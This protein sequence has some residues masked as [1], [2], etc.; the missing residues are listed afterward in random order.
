MT[1]NS[2]TEWVGGLVSPPAHVMDRDEPYRVQLALWLELPGEM[3][4]GFEVVPPDNTLAAVTRSLRRAIQQPMTGR[5]RRPARVRVSDAALA[6][7]ARQVLGPDA[8]VEMAP[9]PELDAVMATFN[10]HVS[11]PSE[12]ASYLEQ[13]RI[14]T[15]TMAAFFESARL[16]YSV[17]PWRKASDHEIL[18]MEIPALGIRGACVSIIGILGESLGLIVFPSLQGYEAFVDAADS[19]G[20]GGRRPRNLGT[21]WVSLNFERG[22]DLPAGLRRE[23]AAHRW[24]VA[25]PEA[26]PLAMALDPDLVSRPLLSR[27]YRVLEAC[28]RAVAAFYLKHADLFGKDE[29]PPVSESWFDADDLEVR[30][31][32]PYEAHILFE[33][34]QPPRRQETRVGRN[35]P[36]PCGSGR[37]YKKCCLSSHQQQHRQ[38]REHEQVHERDLRWVAQLHRYAL[39]RFGR[40]F[41]RGFEDFLEPED[42]LPL[43][44]PWLVFGRAIEGRTVVDWFLEERGR[45]LPAADRAW[46]EA[47]RDAWLSLWEVT[48]VIPGERL[49][50]RDLLTGETREIREVEG[51]KFA[52]ARDTLLARVVDFEGVSLLCGMHPRVLPPRYAAVALEDAQAKL[53]RKRAVPP[54]RLND[55]KFGRHL[56]RTWDELVED[57]DEEQRRPREL[58]NTDGDP[59]LLTIDRFALVDT[60]T[61][62]LESRLLALP[63]VSGP[64]TGVRDDAPRV[65][66]FLRPGGPA[67]GAGGSTVIGRAWIESQQLNVETNSVRRADDLRARLESVL[68]GTLRHR[69]REHSDPLSEAFAH[70]RDAPA[71]HASAASP[72]AEEALLEYKREHYRRWLDE[73]IPALDGKTPRQAAR[74]ARGRAELDL[75]LRE[76]E[77]MEQ[78]AA[79]AHAYDFGELRKALGLDTGG[80]AARRNHLP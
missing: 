39:Q 18:H 1:R 45:A 80:G 20:S 79:G 25:S 47:Q 54:E 17:A 41:E 70:T 43:A 3:I 32:L 33:P 46:L 28:A 65:F 34:G 66:V 37:K 38:A 2:K 76:M 27:D 29:I 69:S 52:V 22:A 11:A 14:D 62:G 74:T 30:L 68:Q 51:S 35:D 10:D 8:H 78:R 58:S 40:K 24:P 57:F 75:L 48:G 77:N 42:A 44:A 72:E 71:A 13:G 53:R 55:G 5:P 12:E 7:A 6:A 26:Y 4:V 9:T 63:E 15:K 31:T 59:L 16:L 19:F 56:I 67:A 21:G 64:P 49:S 36:C 60:D 61:A 23:I 73:S 50:M